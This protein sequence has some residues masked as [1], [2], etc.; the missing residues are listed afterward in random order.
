M[1]LNG[2]NMSSKILCSIGLII[3]TST[4]TGFADS[5]KLPL[6]PNS[7][8]CVSSQAAIDDS[9]FIA[10]FKIIADTAQVWT[11][12]KQALNNQNRTVITQETPDSLDAEAASLIFRFVDDINVIL[13]S[14]NK[15][16]HIRSASRVGYGDF[17]VNRQRVEQLRA[18]L[19]QQ[20]LIE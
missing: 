19:Q 6:C 1:Q 18:Q 4:T 7:P 16:I 15:L 11:A 2:K 9:H 10:P 13:D 5:K 14:D 3:M 12:L 20:K 8:N 17:G